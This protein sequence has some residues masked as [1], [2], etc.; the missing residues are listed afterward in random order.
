MAAYGIWRYLK[1]YPWFS[2]L[3]NLYTIKIDKELF[4]NIYPYEKEDKVIEN[5]QEDL[6]EDLVA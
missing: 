2:I 4:V 1:N 5:L 3:I 6:C